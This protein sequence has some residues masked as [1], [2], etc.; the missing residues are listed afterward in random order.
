M[1]QVSNWFINARVRLWKPMVEQMYQQEFQEEVQP[2]T[3]P[4]EETASEPSSHKTGAN[5]TAPPPISL[6]RTDKEKDPT[7]SAACHDA[8]PLEYRS[9]MADA[10]AGMMFRVGSQAGDVSLTLGLRHSENVP[11][12]SRLSIRDF[13]AY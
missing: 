2:P 10:A 4:K 9:F 6:S 8:P 5:T 1:F 13:Q 12:M 3:A 7:S 11:K